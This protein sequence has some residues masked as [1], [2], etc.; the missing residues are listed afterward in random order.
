MSGFLSKQAS[1]GD[2]LASISSTSSG[3]FDFLGGTDIGTEGVAGTGLRGSKW[4]V[5][6]RDPSEICGG[7]IGSAGKFCAVATGSCR[8]SSHAQKR[9]PDLEPG[10][11]IRAGGI[12]KEE[13]MI[14]PR[15]VLVDIPS[16][17]CREVLEKDFVSVQEVVQFFDQVNSEDIVARKQ[18]KFE[19]LDVAHAERKVRVNTKTPSKRT[20]ERGL[21]ERYD[22]LHGSTLEG[23]ILTQDASEILDRV[24]MFNHFLAS[25]VE[26]S[27]TLSGITGE[28]FD[29]LKLEI[30]SWPAHAKASTPMS[31]WIGVAELQDAI[32]ALTLRHEEAMV[33]ANKRWK[34]DSTE[35]WRAGVQSVSNSL[36]RDI[37]NLRDNVRLAVESVEQ[38]VNTVKGNS[39]SEFLPVS[40]VSEANDVVT[41][42]DVEIRSM[43]DQLSRMQKQ[44]QMIVDGKQSGGTLSAVT[45]GRHTFQSIKE[46]DAWCESVFKNEPIPFG[47]F[48]C[49]YGAYARCLTTNEG[50][51]LTGLQIMDRR[52]SLALSPDESLVLECFQHKLP[53]LFIGSNSE[54]KTIFAHLPA[55][56]TR[57]KWEDKHRLKGIRV[58]IRDNKESVRTRY[59]SLIA[60]RLNKFHEAQGIARELLSDTMDFIESVNTFI[61]DTDSRLVDAGFNPELSWDLV[62]KLVYRVFAVDCHDVRAQVKEFLD[63]TQHR[64]MALGCLWGTFATHMVMREYCKHGL[65]NHPSIAAEYVRFLVANS[66]LGR[67]EKVETRV[68]KLEDGMNMIVKRLDALKKVADSALTKAN[69][70][71]QLAK[72]K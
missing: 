59:S 21:L 41:E 23:K 60:Q 12:P 40:S 58:T 44:V 3:K 69:E 42:H 57:D 26:E 37:S 55:L 51:E 52:K 2:G 25:Q 53:K 49:P 16:E 8:V 29:A 28:K 17:L 6:V 30:G 5:L 56:N 7:M 27:Q 10:L 20:R 50:T 15:L 1:P 36:A 4:C 68:L 14:Y 31:L 11:F 64:A 54:H 13:L 66:G 34:K 32:E 9:V 39:W 63:P 43:K 71:Y 45:V 46:L 67:I 62:T 35:D 18:L 33:Q 19:D 22:Q 65:E 70:A 47:P 24:K 61:N 38:Q 72:K 48:A